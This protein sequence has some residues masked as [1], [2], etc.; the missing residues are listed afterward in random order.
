MAD[1]RALEQTL[2]NMSI[3]MA[4]S[5]AEWLK[6]KEL[7]VPMAGQRS[8]ET[9]VEE[10]KHQPLERQLRDRKNN[11]STSSELQSLENLRT[12]TLV[13]NPVHQVD[14]ILGRVAESQPDLHYM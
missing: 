4:D 1:L 10:E 11:P 5:R 8:L 2:E 9:Q 12:Q 14:F 6:L 3:E 7:I 13:A